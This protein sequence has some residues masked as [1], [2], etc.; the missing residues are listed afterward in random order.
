MTTPSR[1][2]TATQV[3]G[4]LDTTDGITL[5]ID[6]GWGVDALL[7]RQTRVH[8]DLDIVIAEV[9]LPALISTLIDAGYERLDGEGLVL[10]SPQA[11]HVDVHTVTFDNQGRGCFAL[12]DGRV[13]P[14]PPSAFQGEG[15]I[16]G[17]P[18]RC[19]SA[20]AQ[21]HCHAQG[22]PPT[23]RD[24]ADMRALEAA[25]GV[26]LPLALGARFPEPAD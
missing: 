17:R 5:W 23:A 13:W 24:I 26:F 10:R 16:D 2:A 20:E 19:L 7:Q 1:T 14:F 15:C 12:G 21:V 22:Y 18:V 4:F 11:L 9:S 6:G 3:L 25:F 8:R